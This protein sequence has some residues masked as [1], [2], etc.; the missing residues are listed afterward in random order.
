MKILV[1]GSSGLIGR[2]TTTILRNAG[3]QVE[4]FDLTL[5]LDL[6]NAS[7]VEAA[8]QGCDAVVHTAALTSEDWQNANDVMQLNLLGTWHV[9]HAAAQAKVQRVVYFSSVNALGIFMGARE[10]DYLP[11]DDDHPCYPTIPYGISKK[12]GEEMCRHWTQSTGISTICLRPPAVFGPET[13]KFILDYRQSYAGAE[14]TPYWEYG[15]FLD[16][17]DAAIATLCAL[18]CPDP[19]HVTLLL[20]ADDISSSALGSRDLTQKILPHIEWR[21]GT[22]YET[23][24]F[25]ALINTSYAKEVLGWQPQHRW[26]K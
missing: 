9:L 7:Q 1:T 17:R 13:Y 4:E 5:G 16:V 12:L 26:R 11:I 20:C 19:G 15:A 10:P 3:H 24:P 18:T 25:K 2:E 14:W 21:G 6:L 22:E 8:M 23:E